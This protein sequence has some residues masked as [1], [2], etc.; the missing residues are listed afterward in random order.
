MAATRGRSSAVVD[1]LYWTGDEE[2]DRLLVAQ[3][4]ALLIGYVLDQQVTVQKAFS[5][6]LEIRRRLGHLDARRIARTDPEKLRAAFAQRPAVHRFPAAMADRVRALCEMVVR[7]YGGD[8]AAIWTQA[9]DGADLA[10][11]LGRLPGFGPMKVSG[12]V[13]VLTQQLG[14]RPP[15][16]ETVM[17][18]HPTLGLVRSPEDL[19]EYQARKREHKARMRAMES[20]R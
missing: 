3:P 17:P 16:W 7:D 8:A 2:A 6:P 10:A 11:R 13:A 12:M 4:L 1:R 14:V 19:A 5:G 20:Q 15:G 9:R 18:N